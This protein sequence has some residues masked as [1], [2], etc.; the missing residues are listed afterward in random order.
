FQHLDNFSKVKL[1]KNQAD[2]ENAFRSFIDSGDLE[3]YVTGTNKLATCWQKC[4]EASG[5][6]SD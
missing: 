3:F 4:V 5:C 1:F 6:Y 2:A